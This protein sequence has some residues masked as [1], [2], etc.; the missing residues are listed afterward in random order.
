[1]ASANAIRKAIRESE[2]TQSEITDI[3]ET[4]RQKKKSVDR[5]STKNTQVGDR[6]RLVSGRP[7]Y[8]IG[9]EGVVVGKKQVKFEV[10]MDRAVGR[11]GRQLVVPPGMFEVIKSAEE[12][13]QE[14][15]SEES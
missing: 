10:L 9:E 14:I 3:F 2:L 12:G 4:L 8:L 5:A 7:Q 11:F 6:I 13:L 1:M 15:L